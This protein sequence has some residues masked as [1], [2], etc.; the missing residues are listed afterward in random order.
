MAGKWIHCVTFVLCVWAAVIRTEATLDQA[1]DVTE[2]AE[3]RVRQLLI[4][5]RSEEDPSERQLKIQARSEDPS[6]RQLKIQARSEDPSVKQFDANARGQD[7]R[8]WYNGRTE[9]TVTLD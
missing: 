5:A 4:Q 9:R 1:D 3:D 7:P 8:S 2:D 6:V